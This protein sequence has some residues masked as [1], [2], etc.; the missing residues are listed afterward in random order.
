MKNKSK[1]KRKQKEECKEKVN[2]TKALKWK[3]GAKEKVKG[4]KRKCQE[5]CKQNKERKEA[6]SNRDKWIKRWHKWVGEVKRLLAQSNSL[7]FWLLNTLTHRWF[8]Q[9]ESVSVHILKTNYLLPSV[10]SLKL[11]LDLSLLFSFKTGFYLVI[12]LFSSV[13]IVWWKIW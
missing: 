9:C 12:I 7:R 2:Q 13:K 5:K 11:P 1:T 4:E 6:V 10:S 8:A 3:R